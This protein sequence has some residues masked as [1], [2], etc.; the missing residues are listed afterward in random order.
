MVLLVD[1]TL[2]LVLWRYST[3]TLLLTDLE[4]L[5][6]SLPGTIDTIAEGLKVTDLTTLTDMLTT[7]YSN[8]SN[9]KELL[10][11][12]S[13]LATSSGL[14]LSSKAS[15]PSPKRKADSKMVPKTSVADPGDMHQKKS[16]WTQVRLARRVRISGAQAR[17]RRRARLRVKV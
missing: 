11:A 8:S 15:L 16:S 7:Q 14:L 6:G 9:W 3:E 10:T 2:V 4:D 1:R 12:T 17:L 13:E 5:L